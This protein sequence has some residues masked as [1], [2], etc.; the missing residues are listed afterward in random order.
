ML[1]K[2]L[3]VDSSN[4]ITEVLPLGASSF[5]TRV[6]EQNG[7]LIGDLYRAGKALNMQLETYETVSAAAVSP[8]AAWVCY[9]CYEVRLVDVLNGHVINLL[10]LG[11][12]DPSIP[13]AAPAGA[14]HPQ[15]KTICFDA[16]SQLC[17]ANRDRE[18]VVFD[19][20]TAQSMCTLRGADAPLVASALSPRRL[21][22]TAAAATSSGSVWVW[23]DLGVGGASPPQRVGLAGNGSLPSRSP[24]CL[25]FSA[26]RL[27]CGDEDGLSVLW[28]QEKPGQHSGPAAA[29][30]AERTSLALFGGEAAGVSKHV[31]LCAPC[32]PP[33]PRASGLDAVLLSG[34]EV[35]G[36]RVRVADDEHESSLLLSC[37]RSDS[38]DR[39]QI[40][41]RNAT[42]GA[43]VGVPV[44]VPVGVGSSL[45]HACLGVASGRT[46]LAL[47]GNSLQ[48]FDAS[49]GAP[50]QGVA[51]EGDAISTST[52]ILACSLAPDD[53]AIVC[54]V[55]SRLSATSVVIL[56]V[57]VGEQLDRLAANGLVIGV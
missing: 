47:V 38:L 40:C 46:V 56:S 28:Q 15:V 26:G 30:G 57:P 43:A 2:L 41:I 1:R 9:G 11:L 13:T 21:Q 8:D 45:R 24:S 27:L 39:Q 20:N 49:S 42:S 10:T 3:R 54:L 52:R 55:S 22:P 33:R 53:S 14:S 44:G 18:L 29:G 17:A 6:N 12:A 36:G 23:C 4:P 51:L 31:T 5:W 48:L 25:C 7:A 50:L 37:H 32:V 16:E 35:L 19:L 34:G